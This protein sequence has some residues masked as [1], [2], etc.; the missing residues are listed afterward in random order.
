MLIL[1]YITVTPLFKV[2]PA[3]NRYQSDETFKWRK[4][5]IHNWDGT[6]DIG[7]V[8]LRYIDFRFCCM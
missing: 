5:N 8:G 3:G 7:N 2:L 4:F 6:L 1:E